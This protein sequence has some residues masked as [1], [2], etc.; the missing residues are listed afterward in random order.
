MLVTTSSSVVPAGRLWAAV[1]TRSEVTTTPDP[2]G[3]VVS[4]V[5]V[6]TMTTLAATAAPTRSATA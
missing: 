1:I 3:W 5:R 6:R 4:P 2:T